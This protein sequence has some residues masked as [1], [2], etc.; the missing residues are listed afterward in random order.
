MVIQ[1]GQPMLA[2]DIIDL[3]NGL[4]TNIN[5]VSSSVIALQT[6]VTSLQTTVGGL[7]AMLPVGTILMYDG[8]GWVNNQTLPGWYKCDGANGTPNLVDKFIRGASS[9][10]NGNAAASG[11]TGGAA[12]GSVKLTASH[13][14]EHAHALSGSAS[15]GGTTETGGGHTHTTSGTAASTGAHTH[16]TSGTAA[17]AGGHSHTI[18]LGG[19]TADGVTGGGA[20]MV[21]DALNESTQTN[22]SS[23]DGAH[24]HTTSGTAAEAGGHTHTTS[25]TAAEAGGHTHTFSGSAALSGNTGSYGTA[26]AAQTAVTIATVP[27]YYAVIYIRKCA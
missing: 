24:T 26:A 16:T 7:Q 18:T 22:T 1:K 13:I 5:T 20:R 21:M 25:G 17:E 14:P 4:Q 8:A 11:A 9:S 10:Y 15:V 6:S 23:S 2:Q 27:P 12:S 19:N 3:K